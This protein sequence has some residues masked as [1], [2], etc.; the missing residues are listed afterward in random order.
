[1]LKQNFNKK[2]TARLKTHPD[3][4]DDAGELI[5]DAVRDHAW[6]LNHNLIKLLLTDSEIKATF[7]DEIEDIG[8]STITLSST[9]S[10]KKLPCQFLH[11]IP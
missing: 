1:M 6:Q 9:T 7:L 5:L 8:F 4:L 10:L 2:L 11:P 3:F